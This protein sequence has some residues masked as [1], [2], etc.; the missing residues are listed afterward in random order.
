MYENNSMVNSGI[1]DVRIGKNACVGH[2]K[3]N[4]HSG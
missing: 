1:L 3:S 2:N 4:C